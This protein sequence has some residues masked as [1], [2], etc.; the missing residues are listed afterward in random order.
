MAEI[1]EEA[2]ELDVDRFWSNHPLSRG[3][4]AEPLTEE[5][6]YEVEEILGYKL[7]PI[8][9]ELCQIQN[10]GIPRCTE[11][12]FSNEGGEGGGGILSLHSIF[13]I[14]IK[15][16]A[17]LAGFYGN[18]FLIEEWDYPDD[19]GIYFAD[20]LSIGHDVFCLD[21]RQCGSQ[22]EPAVVHVDRERGFHI[23]PIA[24]NLKTF[25]LMLKESTSNNNESEVDGSMSSY[26][27][28]NCILL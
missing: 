10:G 9:I 23:Q 13:G 15:H 12:H 22:G 25:L 28:S 2:N 20:S 16:E 3:Y 1:L 5:L 11:L 7:P 21:Y 18:Q 4:E 14:G 26:I 27:G 24:P 17:S 8:Y 19:I 6:V